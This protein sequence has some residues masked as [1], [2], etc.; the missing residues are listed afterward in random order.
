MNADYLLDAEV[1]DKQN[2]ATFDPA[3]SRCYELRF[4]S[5]LLLPMG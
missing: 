4:C 1:L 5:K 3:D 2:N